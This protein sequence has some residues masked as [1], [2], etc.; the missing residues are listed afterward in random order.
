MI[1]LA[2]DHAE[3]FLALQTPKEH[4]QQLAV[5][6]EMIRRARQKGSG[7]GPDDLLAQLRTMFEEPAVPAE[8]SDE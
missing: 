8:V 5:S 3:A 6:A 1:Q 2:C 4:V 7:S